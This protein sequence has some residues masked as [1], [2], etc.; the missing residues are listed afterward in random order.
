MKRFVVL[1][2][3]IVIGSM[4]ALPAGVIGFVKPA[5]GDTAAG[6]DGADRKGTVWVVNRD[7]GTLA[8]FDAATGELLTTPPLDVGT[9]AHDICISE[10]TG[11]AYITAEGDNAVTVVDT[12]T[13]GTES[14]PVGPG[15]HHV[16]PSNDGH[17]IYVSLLSHTAGGNGAQY[18]VI[19]TRD[20]SVTYRTS[21]PDAG[22]RS[23][24]ITPTLDG[25]TLYIAHDTGNRVT[26]VNAE[27]GAINFTLLNIP[28]AEETVASRSGELLWVSARGGNAVIRVDLTSN[29]VA[30]VGP[31]ISVG[32][33]PESMMLTPNERTLV[34]SLRGSPASLSFV[35]TLAL[36]AFPLVRIGPE[37]TSLGD[38]AVM[39]QNGHFV[40]ATYDNNI[41]G[42]GGIAVV[43]V[44]TREVVDRW[45]YPTTGRP[46]GIWYSKKT[47]RH[48]VAGH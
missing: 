47:P 33:Q 42:T 41:P 4:S 8:I 32:S 30:V 29:P 40:Y 43:D 45:Q 5:G 27:S 25:E 39:T 17:T 31:P 3:A 20:H 48:S 2:A 34:V 22:T 19:D 7:W 38:L 37:D 15:P 46:H 6:E 10:Q 36:S 35:D 24:A 21:S 13:L 1:F 44:R 11:K 16:E 23:H 18:A 9:G 28:R 14:I 26:G 12:E